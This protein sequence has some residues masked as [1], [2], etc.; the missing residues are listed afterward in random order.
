MTKRISSKYSVCKKL[1]SSYKNLWGLKKKDFCRSLVSK[2]KKRSTPFSRLLNIKQSLKFFYSNIGEKFLKRC[3]K[4]SI[5]SPSKTIDKL[6]SILESR[7]DT[8]IFRSCLVNSFQEARQ[9]INHGFVF[10][11]N[12]CVIKTNKKINKGDIIRVKL[13]SF[14]Q[15]LFLRNLLSR[16]IPNYLELDL[17]NL[18]IAL[19]W[20]VNFKNTYYP[21]K[22]KY[23]DIS[24]YYK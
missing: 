6:S 12:L 18:S 21:I 13:K 9:L 7:V 19:L 4:V 11:N 22:E 5:K 20:D 14:N 8:I 3:I 1:K 23:V 16:S 17:N 24:R 10:V 15:D 2:K